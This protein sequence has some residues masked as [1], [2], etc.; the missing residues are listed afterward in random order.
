MV[1]VVGCG[2]CNQ[3]SGVESQLINLE[4]GAR[5]CSRSRI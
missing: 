2:Q 4:Y 5:Y 1:T 3:Y